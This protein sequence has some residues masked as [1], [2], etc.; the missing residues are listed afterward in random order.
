MKNKKSR[1][2]SLVKKSLYIE[3]DGFR[4]QHNIYKLKKEK[5]KYKKKYLKELEEE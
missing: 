4:R 2:K 1:T 3:E 5:E